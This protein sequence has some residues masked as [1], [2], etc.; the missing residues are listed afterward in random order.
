MPTPAQRWGR[1]VALGGHLL[2][3]GPYGMGPVQ[4][5]LVAQQEAGEVHVLCPLLTSL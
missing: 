2:R 5:W 3:Q 1:R 4:G